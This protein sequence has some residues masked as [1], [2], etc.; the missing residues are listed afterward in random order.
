MKRQKLVITVIDHRSDPPERREKEFSAHGPYLKAMAQLGRLGA[1]SGVQVRE[2]TCSTVTLWSEG[3]DPEGSMNQNGSDS[4]AETAGG[5]GGSSTPPVGE[6]ERSITD[7]EASENAEISSGQLKRFH[8][9]ARDMGWSKAAKERLLSHRY[10][11]QSSSEIRRGDQY[12]EICDEA[13]RSAEL[14]S[15]YERDPDT[16]DMFSEANASEANASGDGA[17]SEKYS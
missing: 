7:A 4:D 9:I 6:A 17:T 5:E 13:L 16:P 1:S 14:R 15:R 2:E 3:S 8:A 11:L 10:G 12:N